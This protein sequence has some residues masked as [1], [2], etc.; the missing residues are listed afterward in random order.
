MD[1][2]QRGI[3][4]AQVLQNPVYQEA[5]KSIEQRLIAELTKIEI[6]EERARYIRCLL[7]C[8]SKIRQYLEQ[9][10]TTGKMVEIE[11]ER[12]SLFNRAKESVDRL[13]HSRY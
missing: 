2:I 8:N 13:I 6:P 9:V 12:K 7:I 11:E 3:S 5:F 4:A 10:V 1:D